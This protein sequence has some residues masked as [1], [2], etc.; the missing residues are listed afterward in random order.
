MLM[1]PAVVLNG[2]RI[3]QLRRILIVMFVFIRKIH[4]LV[5]TL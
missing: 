2:P 1:T 4:F 3:V 5:A